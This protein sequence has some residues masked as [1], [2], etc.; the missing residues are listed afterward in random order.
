MVYHTAHDYSDY[1]I[2]DWDRRVVQNVFANTFSVT[3]NINRALLLSYTSAPT[4]FGGHG[5]IVIEKR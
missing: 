3:L 5:A 1:E 4:P 2:E